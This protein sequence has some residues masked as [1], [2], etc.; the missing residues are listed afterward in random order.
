MVE[1]LCFVALGLLGVVG[2]G[3]LLLCALAVLFLAVRLAPA[4]QGKKLERES[5]SLRS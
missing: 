2:C 5:F 1:G 4:R 3:C